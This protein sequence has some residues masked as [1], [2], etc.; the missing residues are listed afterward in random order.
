MAA[1]TR[2][3]NSCPVYGCASE[4]SMNQLPSIENVMQFY[5]R[6]KSEHSKTTAASIII[7][8]V[9]TNVTDVWIKAGI[10]TNTLRSTEHKLEILHQELRN[11]MKKKAE[12]KSTAI[13]L[14]QSNGLNCLNCLLLVNVLTLMHAAA[15]VI[16]KF[17]C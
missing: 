17:L 9:A 14:L 4:L 8:E 3:K 10:P 1:A 12:I 2:A 6:K 7:N 13:E 15:N 11:I 5:V 16:T